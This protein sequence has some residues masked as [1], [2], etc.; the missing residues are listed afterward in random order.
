MLGCGLAVPGLPA[1]R[2][3]GSPP[4]GL[5]PSRLPPGGAAAAGA[6]KP[7][8]FTASPPPRARRAGFPLR[9]EK[10]TMVCLMRILWCVMITEVAQL[11]DERG[12]FML[13]VEVIVDAPM[14]DAQ[15]V[16]ECICMALES[17]P[18]VKRVRVLGVQP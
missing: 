18:G 7:A 5:S 6:V 9:R 4:P 3:R 12:L 11:F 10:I 14:K 16:K 1:A 8:P 15:G 2:V 13:K 17:V